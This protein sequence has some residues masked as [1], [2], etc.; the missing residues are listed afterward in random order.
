[1]AVGAVL[2]SGV[3][4]VSAGH[5]SYYAGAPGTNW[6]ASWKW[7]TCS[8][9]KNYSKDYSNHASWIVN[10][11]YSSNVTWN[12]SESCYWWTD[13]HWNVKHSSHWSHGSWGW[14]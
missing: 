11:H 2:L 14:C 7:G 10:G 12:T 3:E 5:E 4:E 9:N 13:T 1:L 6:H 8:V